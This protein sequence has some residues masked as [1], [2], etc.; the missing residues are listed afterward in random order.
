MKR[1]PES[2]GLAG[3]GDRIRADNL[4]HFEGANWWHQIRV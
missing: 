2:P 4:H 1:E 3:P